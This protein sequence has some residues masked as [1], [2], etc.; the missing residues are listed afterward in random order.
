MH[1]KNCAKFLELERLARRL[2]T[3]FMDAT[4]ER[5]V[6]REISR[7][8][9]AAAADLMEDIGFT[10]TLTIPG[11]IYR[12]LSPNL[13]LAYWK[14]GGERAKRV[15]EW[16]NRARLAWLESPRVQFTNKVRMDYCI[17][18]VR[19]VDPDNL[20]AAM[21]ALIDGLCRRDGL[22]NLLRG[23]RDADITYGFATQ[24]TGSRLRGREEVVVTFT[25]LVE[26]D[27]RDLWR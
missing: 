15:K 16:R 6:W 21:K 14:G 24:E 2:K 9:A 1:E 13:R 12:A 26:E 18:R 17:R 25:P 10:V 3:G 7:L 19:R 20:L 4:T 22:P 27:P 5:S 11:D 8:A 23:D